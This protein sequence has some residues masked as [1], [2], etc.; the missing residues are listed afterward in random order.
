MFYV[1]LDIQSERISVCAL[2]DPGQVVHRA[3]VRTLEEMMRRRWQAR[4]RRA[5]YPA[6]SP[7][8]ER[9]RRGWAA[10]AALTAT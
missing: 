10:Q 3:Q 5:Q 6:P 9:R 1:G 2:S 4:L 7:K 8:T